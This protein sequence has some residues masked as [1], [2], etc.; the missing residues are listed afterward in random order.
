MAAKPECNPKVLQVAIPE[1]DQKSTLVSEITLN[2]ETAIK[3]KPALNQPIQFDA[4]PKEF[5]KEP[6]ML[7]M[8][9]DSDKTPQLQ[10]EACTPAKGAPA[11][12]KGGASKAAPGTKAKSKAAPK[13]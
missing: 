7:T 9:V 10:V 3:G 4:V 6:F 12:K 5:T 2:L 13:K 1:P 11:S 8:D